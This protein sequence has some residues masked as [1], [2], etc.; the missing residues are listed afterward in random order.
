MDRTRQLVAGPIKVL[1]KILESLRITEDNILEQS[2]RLVERINNIIASLLFVQVHTTSRR[3]Q[4]FPMVMLVFFIRRMY[5][6]SEYMITSSSMVVIVKNRYPFSLI[7]ELVLQLQDANY[8]T[9]LDVC[10][11]F[12]Q[13]LY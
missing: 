7:S 10:W 4:S 9:K 6:S 13:C 8:F 3:Y 1:E 2:N 5:F 11:S 12:Q